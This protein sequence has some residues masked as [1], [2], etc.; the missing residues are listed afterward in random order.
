MDVRAGAVFSVALC[1]LSVG[2]PLVYVSQAGDTR[3][4]AAFLA[5]IGVK[6]H[7]RL[8]V[9]VEASKLEV[10]KEQRAFA[11]E[12]RRREK[13]EAD[14]AEARARTKVA[15]A[16]LAEAKAALPRI[17][18]LFPFE[19]R[20]RRPDLR[21]GLIRVAHRHFSK[22]SGV[23]AVNVVVAGSRKGFG[24]QLRLRRELSE[25]EIARLVG[26]LATF[27]ASLPPHW[28]TQIQVGGESGR[29]AGFELHPAD[30][31]AE[32]ENFV[33]AF[34]RGHKA[35]LP[36]PVKVAGK[37]GTGPAQ[38]KVSN[39]AGVPIKITY[40]GDVLGSVRLEPDQSRDLELPAGRYRVAVRVV[41]K[42]S[43]LPFTGNSSFVKGG[44]YESGYEIVLSW[45][46]R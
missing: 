19:L 1:I 33:D 30:Q 5:E 7:A 39:R 44:S 12:V 14:L 28:V 6:E 11:R 31:G 24:L 26:S 27:R 21:A 45:Q 43:V 35:T 10:A 46:P 13:L 8:V 15:L 18:S 32:V 20:Q 25:G 17:E 34:F 2:G 42:S 41:G 29:F 38:W 16:E 40:Y 37:T 4:R 9:A 36:D 3:A 23:V 22:E